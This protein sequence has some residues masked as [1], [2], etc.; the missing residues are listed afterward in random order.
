MQ[1]RQDMDTDQNE[2]D[3]VINVESEEEIYECEKCNET[4]DNVNCLGKHL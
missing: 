2:E 4:F 3:E 1:T